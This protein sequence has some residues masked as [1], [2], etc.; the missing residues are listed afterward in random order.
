M[1][2]RW[3]AERV[4]ISI[5]YKG[6]RNAPFSLPHRTDLQREAPMNECC[7]EPAAAR[8]PSA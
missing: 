5:H 8:M 4:A 6:L 3:R 2:G 7:A 1:V